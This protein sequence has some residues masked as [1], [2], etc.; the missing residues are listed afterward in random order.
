MPKK[1]PVWFKIA[2][3]GK[4]ADGTWGATPLMKEDNAGYTYTIPACL[5][6]GHYLVRHEIIAL[7]AAYTY[8]GPQFFPGCHQIKVTGGGDKVVKDL[9]SFPGAYVGKETTYDGKSYKV[10]GPAVMKC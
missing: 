3:D 5:K 2:Q 6:A 9:V 7:H 8:P 4:H 1:K 10:P